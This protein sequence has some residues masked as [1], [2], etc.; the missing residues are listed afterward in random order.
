[1]AVPVANQVSTSF[2]E[3]GGSN[4]SSSNNSSTSSLVSLFQ[5]SH[6]QHHHSRS[7]SNESLA[8]S[9]SR[10]D[11]AP[12]SRAMAAPDFVA[13]DGKKRKGSPLGDGNTM[14]S[15][16][17]D[18]VGPGSEA[19]QSSTSPTGGANEAGSEAAKKPSLSSQQAKRIKTARACDSC[20]RKKIRCDVIEDG[21][22]AT[23]DPNNGNGGLTCVHCKQYGFGSCTRREE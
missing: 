7:E 6:Q 17:Q 5:R 3:G 13:T 1:M 8:S 9:L 14:P 12:S 22:P 10:G 23:G 4:S 15:Q 2:G 19:S 16:H 21:G 11:H 20:R 18:S